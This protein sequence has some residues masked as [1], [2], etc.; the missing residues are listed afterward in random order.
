MTFVIFIRG[1]T[2]WVHK[3]QVILVVKCVVVLEGVLLSRTEEEKKRTN[4]IMPY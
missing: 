2:E 1:S 4:D 3:L